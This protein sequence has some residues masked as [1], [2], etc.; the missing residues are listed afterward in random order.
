MKYAFA[1][2]SLVFL[3]ALFILGMILQPAL[4]EAQRPIKV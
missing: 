2:R 3:I 4:A 1:A